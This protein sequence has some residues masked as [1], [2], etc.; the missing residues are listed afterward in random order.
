[1]ATYPS[2]L[3]PLDLLLSMKLYGMEHPFGQFGSADL[4]VSS[5]KLHILNVLTSG[6][7]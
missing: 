3:H 1:M 6:T 4:V 5:L 2:Y 7:Q